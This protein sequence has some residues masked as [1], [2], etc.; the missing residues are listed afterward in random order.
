MNYFIVRL[1]ADVVNVPVCD[2]SILIN[3]EKGS[4]GNPIGCTIRAK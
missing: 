3:Y 2:F 1:L 4:F